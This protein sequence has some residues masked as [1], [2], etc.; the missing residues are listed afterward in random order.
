MV[1]AAFRPFLYCLYSYCV[2]V[3]QQ[4]SMASRVIRF[5]VDAYQELLEQPVLFVRQLTMFWN[6]GHCDTLSA[7]TNQTSVAGTGA[8]CLT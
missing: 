7:S 5:Q 2:Y 1:S 6:V 4:I 3:E 8:R